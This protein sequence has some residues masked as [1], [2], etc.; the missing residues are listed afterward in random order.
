[1]A[2]ARL[3]KIQ[4]LTALEHYTTEQR[5]NSWSQILTGNIIQHLAS[6]FINLPTRLYSCL[7]PMSG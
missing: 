1:M 5:T 6:N 7:T 4:S 3:I 2:N